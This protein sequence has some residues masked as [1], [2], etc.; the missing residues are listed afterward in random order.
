MGECIKSLSLAPRMLKRNN[1]R[2]LPL[3]LLL[4]VVVVIQRYAVRLRPELGVALQWG[5]Q[6][7]MALALRCS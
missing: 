2:W 1:N 6:E 3:L 7:H 4:V 5:L